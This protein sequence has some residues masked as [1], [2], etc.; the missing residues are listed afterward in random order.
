[1]SQRLQGKTVAEGVETPEEAAPVWRLW[2]SGL[3]RDCSSPV[4]C[5]WKSSAFYWKSNRPIWL[6]RRESAGQA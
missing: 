1:M 3:P 6:T 5:P 2:V 4:Q